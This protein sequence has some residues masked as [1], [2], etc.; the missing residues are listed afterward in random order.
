VSLS[1]PCEHSRLTKRKTN[2]FPIPWL[3]ALLRWPY[4]AS[5]FLSA[6]FPVFPKAARSQNYHAFLHSQCFPERINQTLKAEAICPNPQPISKATNKRAPGSYLNKASIVRVWRAA[7][8]S[9]VQTRSGWAE[10]DIVL[11][12]DISNMPPAS[13][14]SNRGDCMKVSLISLRF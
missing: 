6:F 13:K 1:F 8:F 14:T 3:P 12:R 9:T 2:T 5:A 4:S 10:S 7:L 11:A